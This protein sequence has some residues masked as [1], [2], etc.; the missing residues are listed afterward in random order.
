MTVAFLIF[1]RCCCVSLS[2]AHNTACLCLVFFLP[3]QRA[4]VDGGWPLSLLYK[5]HA[6]QP[7]KADQS[8]RAET[9]IEILISE[10]G[11]KEPSSSSCRAAE[12]TAG[13]DPAASAATAAAEGRTN[14][15]SIFFSFTS[16]SDLLTLSKK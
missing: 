4:H 7:S 2:F 9:Q 14:D 16:N 13:A 8:T 12:A 3:Q 11:R 1:C 6:H 15:F 10:E 5:S